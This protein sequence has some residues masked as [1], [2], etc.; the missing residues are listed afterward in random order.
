MNFG[1]LTQYLTYDFRQKRHG[2]LYLE[3]NEKDHLYPKRPS[4]SGKR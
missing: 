1:N 4:S 3:A 2:P